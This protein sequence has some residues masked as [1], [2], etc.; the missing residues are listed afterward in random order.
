[1]RHKRSFLLSCFLLTAFLL[2]AC[3][4][5]NRTDLPSETSPDPLNTSTSDSENT[6][7]PD[8]DKTPAESETFSKYAGTQAIESETDIAANLPSEPETLSESERAAEIW[9]AYSDTGNWL[10]QALAI[11]MDKKQDELSENDYLSVTELYVRH[12][13]FGSKTDDNHSIRIIW[14]EDI[15]NGKDKEQEDGFMTF[16]SKEKDIMIPHPSLPE[17]IDLNDFT[18]FPNLERMDI[19]YYHPHTR[20]YITHYESLT[21]LQA[22]ESLYISLGVC[23]DYHTVITDSVSDLSFVRQM[24]SLTRI[25]FENVYL[26]DDLS[27]FFERHFEYVGLRNCGITEDAFAGLNANASYPDRLDLPYNR[28]SDATAL[29]A[30]QGDWGGNNID[31]LDL[32]WNPLTV[33]GTVTPP[34]NGEEQVLWSRLG[35]IGLILNG[36]AFDGDS[37][38]FIHD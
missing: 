26:P 21:K 33:L 7:A 32:S 10:D 22:L 35:A 31:Y 5:G 9:D 13:W 24:P 4:T 1:M 20:P 6:A 3:R 29:T 2:A 34:H 19:E 25:T 12:H 37:Y 8:A 18:K 16:S 14:D 28:I 23:D 36:T 11:C 17:Q 30:M 27:L 38:C 15:R